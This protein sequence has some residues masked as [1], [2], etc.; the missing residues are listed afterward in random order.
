VLAHGGAEPV[1]AADA[2]EGE[3]VDLSV[4]ELVDCAAAVV[5]SYLEWLPGK[6]LDVDGI[7][8]VRVLW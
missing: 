6:R 7:E 5:R 4:D 1:L 8:R 2:A 3:F